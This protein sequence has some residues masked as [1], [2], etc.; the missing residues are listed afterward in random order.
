M[1]YLTLIALILLAGCTSLDS[2]PEL[3]ACLETTTPPAMDGSFRKKSRRE[4]MEELGWIEEHTLSC[5]SYGS[6]QDEYI[7]KVLRGVL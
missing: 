1:K 7:P 4:C 2:N 5:K 3:I 6:C